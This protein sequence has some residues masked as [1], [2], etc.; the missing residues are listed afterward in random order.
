MFR[1][2]VAEGRASAAAGKCEINA[3]AFCACAR[4]SRRVR[5]QA[6]PGWSVPALGSGR[7]DR[8]FAASHSR[9][10]SVSLPSDGKRRHHEFRENDTSGRM[11]AAAGEGG[12]WNVELRPPTVSEDETVNV[13]LGGKTVAKIR[14]SGRC[15]VVSCPRRG[16]SKA[17]AAPESSALTAYPTLRGVSVRGGRI[18]RFV[19]SLSVVQELATGTSVYSEFSPKLLD[20]QASQPILC[21]YSDR[22]QPSCEGG[23]SNGGAAVG[24]TIVNPRPCST[25]TVLLAAPSRSRRQFA[26]FVSFHSDRAPP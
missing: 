5:C 7:G 20:Q 3:R 18:Q 21:R 16:W 24:D 19:V 2:H 12:D 13:P 26:N 11:G 17:G 4:Q 22:D 15:L 14:P 1:V 23:L 9:Y 10:P 8:M 6:R 25:C